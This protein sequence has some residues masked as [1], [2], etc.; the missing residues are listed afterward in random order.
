MHRMNTSAIMDNRIILFPA[1]FILF[2]FAVSKHRFS[3]LRLREEACDYAERRDDEC[4]YHIKHRHAEISAL[5]V[6][7]VDL[8]CYR[9]RREVDR[10]PECNTADAKRIGKKVSTTFTA[11]PMKSITETVQP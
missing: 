9:T 8:I 6:H 11:K 2:S 3:V 10:K 4:A 5:V 1:C 7:L